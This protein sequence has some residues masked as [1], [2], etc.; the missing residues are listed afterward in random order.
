MRVPLEIC[1]APQR[2]KMV[3]R[4]LG[5]A[6]GVITHWGKGRSYPCPGEESCRTHLQ[7][8]WKGYAPAQRWFQADGLWRP[9]VFEMT[10]ALVEVCGTEDLRGKVLAVHRQKTKYGKFQVSAD[11]LIPADPMMIPAAFC[12]VS[13][14]ERLYRTKAIAWDIPAGLFLRETA[15][16]SM[17]A[18]PVEKI[19]PKP[20]TIP[21]SQKSALEEFKKKIAEADEKERKKNQ[22]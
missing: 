4:L 20:D 10:E 18:P 19:A 7:S 8:V 12:V 14:V 1:S 6:R 21:I 22:A 16:C 3:V 11:E 5:A 13:A 15:E 9:V 2:G 17:D